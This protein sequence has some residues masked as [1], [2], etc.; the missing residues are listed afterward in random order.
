M[1]CDSSVGTALRYGLDDRGSRIRFPAAAGKFSLHHRVQNISGPPQPTIQWVSGALSLEVKR[2][3]REAGHS[4]HLVP[5]SKNEWSY[6]QLPQYAF[7]LW[8]F[9]KHMDKFTF[10]LPCLTYDRRNPRQES[11]R[12][13]SLYRVLPLWHPVRQDIMKKRR[14]RKLTEGRKAYE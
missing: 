3:G 11:K 9:F 8:C 7:M 1:G 13:H 4:T 10:T 2:P 14:K 12:V 5:R 6:P